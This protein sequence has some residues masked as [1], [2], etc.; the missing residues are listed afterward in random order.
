M[1]GIFKGYDL[2]LGKKFSDESTE[3]VIGRAASSPEKLEN[4]AIDGY[5]REHGRAPDA[6]QLHDW[7]RTFSAAPAETEQDGIRAEALRR[8]QV[9]QL[10][11][12]PQGRTRDSSK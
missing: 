1:K 3:L 12:A 8:L 11:K 4:Q 9:R 2:E 10:F 7:M 5:S 6:Q